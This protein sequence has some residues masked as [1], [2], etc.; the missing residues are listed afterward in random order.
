MS[1]K[2]GTRGFTISGGGMTV[3][4]LVLA[5]CA[6]L[7]AGTTSLLGRDSEQDLAISVIR[8]RLDNAKADTARILTAVDGLRAD[9]QAV[10]EELIKLQKTGP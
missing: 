7:V 9:L 5:S 2:N 3:I 10:R 6:A 4:S 8:E 1:E